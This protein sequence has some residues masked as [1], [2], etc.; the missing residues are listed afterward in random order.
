MMFSVTHLAGGLIA[1]F[2]RFVTAAS[3]KD[4][5]Q[6]RR[7][8]CKHNFFHFQFLL[9]WNYTCGAETLQKKLYTFFTEN[10]EAQKKYLFYRCERCVL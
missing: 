1:A 3:G 2:L 4:Q 7:Q 9:C 6:S 10:Q 8:Q 5:H